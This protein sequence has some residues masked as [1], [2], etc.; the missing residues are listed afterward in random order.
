MELM[1][2]SKKHGD[3]IVFFDDIDAE[4]I[5][6]HN[7]HLYKS[8][9]SN[10]LY[11]ITNKKGVAQK[12]RRQIFMHR[13]IIKSS[14]IVDHKDGNG[15][16]NRRNNLRE[17]TRAQNASNREKTKNN[18][19]GFK[20]VSWSLSAKKWVVQI[21]HEGII[22]TEFFHSKIEAAK[23]YNELAVQYHGEFARLNEISLP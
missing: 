16:N 6:S 18:T 9:T 4:M 13:L 3:H 23:R 14:S 20:G 8:R 2:K 21:T 19:S 22:I 10:I 1:I 7:W 11:A 17:A 5:R 12:D 15:L